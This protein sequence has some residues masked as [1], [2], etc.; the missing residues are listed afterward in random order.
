[1]SSPLHPVSPSSADF[2]EG[3]ETVLNALLLL[4]RKDLP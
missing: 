3:F 1:M 4:A 2:P